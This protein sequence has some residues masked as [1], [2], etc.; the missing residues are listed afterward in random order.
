MGSEGPQRRSRDEV[1]DRAAIAEFIFAKGGHALPRGAFGAHASV[2]LADRLA[3]RRR[4]EQRE[5]LRRQPDH[6]RI[7]ALV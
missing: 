2:G 4:T 1:E 5:A 3:L 7:E 6:C